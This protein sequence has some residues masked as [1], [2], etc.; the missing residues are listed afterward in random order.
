MRLVLSLTILFFCNL[1]TR[2]NKAVS[3]S[4]D[5]IKAEAYKNIR[6]DFTATRINTY[7]ETIEI[8]ASLYNDNRDTVY[9]LSSSCDGEQYALRY[10]TSAFTLTPLLN[11]NSS[12]PK[13][14]KI[15]PKERHNFNAHFRCNNQQTK[16]KLG[17]DFYAIDKSFDLKQK[18]LNDIFNRPA[19]KQTIIWAAGKT[20]K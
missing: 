16:I 1:T 6:F 14:I 2:E 17:F 12:F 13:R 9:F 4:T 15:A 20:I 8:K 10:D 19:A 3:D 11:C 7:K 5:S 18:S